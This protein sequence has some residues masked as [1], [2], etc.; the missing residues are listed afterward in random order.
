MVKQIFFLTVI[1]NLCIAVESCS[2][3][4]G[5]AGKRDSDFDEITTYLQS[6]IDTW[7]IPGIAIAITNDTNIVYAKAFG[8][9][10]LDTKEK[11]ETSNTGEPA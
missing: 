8:V 11:L 4:K 9:K 10:N 5:Y 6:L 2:S 7:G 3:S 1:F